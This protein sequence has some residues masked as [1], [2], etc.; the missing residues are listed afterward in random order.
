ME[1]TCMSLKWLEHVHPI[2]RHQSGYNGPWST[3]YQDC[4]IVLPCGK[5]QLQ[6]PLDHKNPKDKKYQHLL[7]QVFQPYKKE[8][9]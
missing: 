1:L 4:H 3:L 2:I 8:Q 7:L 6:N 9:I 5:N